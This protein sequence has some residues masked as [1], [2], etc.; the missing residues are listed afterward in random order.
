MD[1]KE[2][3]TNPE[4]DDLLADLEDDWGID[5]IQKITKTKEKI[6]WKTKLVWYL[7]LLLIFLIIILGGTYYFFLFSVK[8]QDNLTLYESMYVNTIKSILLKVFSSS[9]FSVSVNSKDVPIK[10]DINIKSYLQNPWILFYDKLKFKELLKNQNYSLIKSNYNDLK[11][12]QNLLVQYK[13]FPKELQSV[14]KNIRILPILTTLNSIKLYV[15][16]YVY[17]K[18]W[19]FKQQIFDF[20]YTRSKFPGKYRLISSN[21]LLDYIESDIQYFKDQG[22]YEY[23]KNIYF[24]YMYTSDDTLAN[25][26]FVNNFQNIFA[27]R[28]NDRYNQFKRIYP[29][30]DKNK[31]ITDY[32][33]FIKNV[34]AR[35]LNLGKNLESEFLPVD[36]QLLSY[37]PKSENLSFSIKLMLSPEISS[38]IWVIQ[39]LSDIVTLLRE[40]RL[41]I[42]KNI[43]YNTV[44]VKKITKR[45]GGYKLSFIT[46]SQKFVTSVQPKVDLEV[47]DISY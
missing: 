27:D 11:K 25:S 37:D 24:N 14:V 39:L 44:K 21:E 42:W 2:F 19:L 10:Q 12:Y 26:Y 46:A 18:S 17:I 16:D 30:L 32:V 29:F 13:F 3:D 47:T 22:T 8:P 40:S 1:K 34:Y 36:V 23:L 15:T 41:I 43:S 31:F 28:L 20:V 7:T 4:M 33:E 45:V 38:K 6:S 35:T 5:S 9:N